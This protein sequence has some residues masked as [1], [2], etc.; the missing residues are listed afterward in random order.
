MWAHI[1]V[2]YSFRDSARI[3]AETVQ[4]IESVL[5]SFERFD[6]ALT[7]V[8]CFRNPQVV[9]YLAPEPAAPFKAMTNAF[10]MEFTDTP[11][12]GGVF[13]EFIPHVQVADEEDVEIRATIEAD[14]GPHLPIEATTGEV[15]LVEHGPDGWRL[16]RSF[17]LANSSPR[18]RFTASTP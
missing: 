11:P 3:D 8:E 10:A 16:R 17:R 1:T 2:I 9:L 6:F 7:T 13:D 18:G 15:E 4:A 5:A 14:V 12:Y